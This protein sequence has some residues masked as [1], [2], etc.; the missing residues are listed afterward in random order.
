MIEWNIIKL[1]R[2]SKYKDKSNIVVAVDW[3][4]SAQNV[5]QDL[6]GI[7]YGKINF[8]PHNDRDFIEFYD[9]TKDQV[10]SWIWSVV[11]KKEW[12]Q[13]ALDK[14]SILEL[15]DQGC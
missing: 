8:N 6:A 9:L 4:V 2:L 10:L 7:V 1:D 14:L 3:A 13:K 12:E 15:G 11:D 5:P